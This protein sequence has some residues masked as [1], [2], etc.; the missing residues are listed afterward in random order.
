MT[1]GKGG[2]SAAGGGVECSECGEVSGD[3]A[4]V[5]IA[6]GTGFASSRGGVAVAYN[7]P[8]FVC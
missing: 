1:G 8:A 2:S 4:L 5:S 6:S 3:R 7:S